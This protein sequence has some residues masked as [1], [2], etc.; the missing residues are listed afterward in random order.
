MLQILQRKQPRSNKWANLTEKGD[1]IK[2]LNSDDVSKSAS[3][4]R[5]GKSLIIKRLIGL[6]NI[7]M[8]QARLPLE[9]LTVTV[10]SIKEDWQGQ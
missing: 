9:R 1:I 4:V 6:I 8:K 5:K 10:P 7:F 3:F 2:N